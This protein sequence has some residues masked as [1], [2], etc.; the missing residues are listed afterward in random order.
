MSSSLAR[1]ILQLHIIK[2]PIV[3]DS[4]RLHTAM[5]ILISLLIPSIAFAKWGLVV[6]NIGDYPMLVEI[7]NRYRAPILLPGMSKRLGYGDRGRRIT[8]CPYVLGPILTLCTKATTIHK[9]PSSALITTWAARSRRTPITMVGASD[10]LTGQQNFMLYNSTTDNQQMILRVQPDS[11]TDKN[12]PA[13]PESVVSVAFSEES[14]SYMQV[15]GL[16]WSPEPDQT[17]VVKI[18]KIPSKIPVLKTTCAAY[19]TKTGLRASCEQI[20]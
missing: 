5:Y 14:H 2:R 19:V 3:T 8:L 20:S 1:C 13:P 18:S 11:R 17:L 4:S 10:L 6:V 15:L 9:T 16:T 7:N 12:L